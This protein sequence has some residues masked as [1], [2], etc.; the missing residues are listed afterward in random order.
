MKKFTFLMIA[1]LCAVVTFAAGPKKQFTKLPFAPAKTSVQLGKQFS[2]NKL[3]KNVNKRGVAKTRA[4]RRAV[5]AADL[6]GTYLWEYAQADEC[7]QDPTTVE[8]TAGS[9]DVTISAGAQEGTVTISGMF[10]NDLTGT[11][12][13]DYGVIVVEGGQIIGTSQYGDYALYGLFY[14]EGDADYEAGWY[15]NDIYI[16]INNDGTLIFEDWLVRVLTGGQ[17]DGYS[18]T[19]YWMPE[20]TLTPAEAPQVVVAPVGLEFKEYAMTYTDYNEKAASGTAYVGIDGT[21]V[22]I[23]G[24]SSYIPDALIKGTKDGNTITFPAN[25]FLGNYAGYNSYFI[26]EA[27]FTYDAGNDT[28]TATGDVYSILGGKYIDVYATNPVLKGVVEKAVMPANPAITALTNG[29]YGYY[30]NFNVPNVD[31]DG[32]GMVASKLSYIIYTDIEGKISP[33]TFTPDTHI[34]LTENLTEIPYGFT[35]NYDFYDKLIYLN[36]LYSAD[37]NNLG[38]QSIYRGGGEENA[39]EIQWFHIKDYA[40][41]TFDPST[42]DLPEYVYDFNDGTLQGWTTIDA[43]GDGYNWGLRGYGVDGTNAAYSQSYVKDVGAL[44]PDNYLVSPKMVLDGC[45]TFYACAQDAAYPAE[46]FAVA[47]STKGNK[48]AADFENV[49]VWTL[50][51]SRMANA[52]RRAQGNWYEYSV[53][54]RAFEGKEGYVAIRH[55][56]CTDQ[57]YIVVDNIKLK[58]SNVQQPDIVVDPAEGMID[59]LSTIT[60]TFNNYAVKA[61]EGAKAQLYMNGGEEPVATAN[62][63]IAE[64]KY[65]TI[66]FAEQTA[67]G[68]YTVVIPA[69]SVKN[70]TADELLPELTYSYSIYPKELVKLPVGVETETWYYT[71]SAAYDA[72]KGAEVKVAVDGTDI[73]IQ[74]ISQDMPDSWIKGTIDTGT[75][76]ATFDYGQYLGYNETYGYDLWFVPTTDGSTAT[77]GIFDYDA[78]KGV[79]STNSYIVIS[80]EP[81]KVSYFEYYYNVEITRDAPEVPVT[82][83]VPEDLVTQPYFLTAFDSYYQEDVTREVLV[84]RYGEN[85]VYIQGLSEYIADAWV[86]GTIDENNVVTVPATL[87]GVYESFFGDEELTSEATTFTY[88]PVADKYTA[89]AFISVGGD[90]YAWDKLESVVLTKVTEVAATPAAPSVKD[91]VLIGVDDN[92]NTTDTDGNPIFVTY[93]HVDFNIPTEDVDG[94]QMVQDKLSYVIYI[95]DEK[96]EQKELTL[97]TGLYVK[98]TENLTEIPYK[99]TDDYDIYT[100]GSIV[101]LNQD[102]NEIITWKKIGVQ[103]IYRGLGEENRSDIGWFDIVAYLKEEGVTGITEV[104]AKADSKN[105]VIFDLQGR[106]VAKPT[107]GLYIVNGKKVLVK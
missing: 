85:E 48:D 38:I 105:T 88:D 54:L 98:L 25:Q 64:A 29:Q 24:F 84:G 14:Y 86:K 75:G 73:F 22:Y 107:K 99:F 63:T 18:L 31:V 52:P 43:D 7:V 70:T 67:K 51:A 36:D 53:D 17:Y 93:P 30:I 44:T 101:Y 13:N 39:T 23:K 69:G 72:V 26:E 87:L 45:I 46:N 50:T 103:S 102:P 57:F 77:K 59:A 6:E 1:L 80:V 3:A 83:E 62:I 5:A 55:F 11:I 65:L 47:V 35:E 71:A 27:V 10:D 12:D 21:D 79:L 92:N 15:Y 78:E 37:W 40:G 68:E 4:S 74:G 58:S 95:V 66:A 41:D 90:G 60:L 32:N 94:N 104:A 56:N 2:A 20:S 49:Q 61:V 106:R 8:G 9:A 81:N 100:G 82:V 19:P 42:I 89:D 33:L 76:T 97:T 34:K 28:Y 16:D 91:F 96:G